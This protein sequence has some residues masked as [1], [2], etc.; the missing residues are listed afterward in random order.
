MK[1]P[2]EID[3][4]VC[5]IMT[6]LEMSDNEFVKYIEDEET[7]LINFVCIQKKTLEKMYDMKDKLNKMRN[8]MK[9][10]KPDLILRNMSRFDKYK[11]LK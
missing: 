2:D 6:I 5:Y 1:T 11:I 3:N 9:K 7:T 4:S 8:N 10:D